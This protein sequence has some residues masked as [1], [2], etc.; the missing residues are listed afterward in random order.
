MSYSAGLLNVQ[1]LNVPGGAGNINAANLN[2]NDL[3]VANDLT[4]GDALSVTGATHVGGAFDVS[5]S[6][7]AGAATLSTLG[8]SSNITTMNTVAKGRNWDGVGA[9]VDASA[10]YV[11]AQSLVST[12][13][14]S[15]PNMFVSFGNA[16]N[17]TITT[18]TFGTQSNGAPVPANPYYRTASETKVTGAVVM[19]KM[20]EERLITMD[21]LV[22]VWLGNYDDTSGINGDKIYDYSGN[23]LIHPWLIQNK[24]FV[25]ISGNFY[26]G[27]DH[28]PTMLPPRNYNAG[29]PDCVYFNY[30]P[31]GALISGTTRDASGV[32]TITTISSATKWAYGPIV[33][34]YNFIKNTTKGPSDPLTGAEGPIQITVKCLASMGLG[35]N[36]DAYWALMNFQGVIQ[37]SGDTD[38][39]ARI[40]EWGYV[41]FYAVIAAGQLNGPITNPRNPTPVSQINNY[42]CDQYLGRLATMPFSAFPFEYYSYSMEYDILG[43]MMDQVIKQNTARRT[44][45]TD[46]YGYLNQKILAPLAITDFWMF[47]GQSQPPVDVSSNMMS[48][49]EYRS[50]PVSTSRFGVDGQFWEFGYGF[51]GSYNT[52]K[53]SDSL[54]GSSNTQ[55]NNDLYYMAKNTNIKH[56][57]TFNAGCATSVDSYSKML[58]LYCNKGYDVVTKTRLI[59]KAAMNYIMQPSMSLMSELV[60]LG[61]ISAPEI[62]DLQIPSNLIWSFGCSMI[63]IGGYAKEE[64]VPRDNLIFPGA[65]VGPVTMPPFPLS[66]G[67]RWWSGSVN[68]FWYCNVDTGAWIH[69]G[70]QQLIHSRRSGLT[71]A[72]SAASLTMPFINILESV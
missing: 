55:L 59:S 28:V 38:Q 58:R 42:G 26:W 64:S 23:V 20:L 21:T 4:V 61:N 34:F 11:Y 29:N 12:A 17:D 48:S 13:S 1:T 22:D 36:Y 16:N 37:G 69:V 52:L 68:T 25:D 9:V 30:D 54:P 40:A 33:N 70:S 19:A 57:G 50:N 53:W 44:Q 15:I 60:E 51:D 65:P 71:F 8:V 18:K 41:G 24:S 10:I 66:P 2:F 62:E 67:S 3:S 47:Y 72:T 45:Y 6:L 31:S 46:I 5:G 14:R 39:S 32:R 43:F 49:S 63:P 7:V 35:I 56:I 27:A